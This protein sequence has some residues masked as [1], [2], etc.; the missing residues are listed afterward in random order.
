MASA[1]VKERVY[2]GSA[3]MFLSKRSRATVLSRH[4]SLIA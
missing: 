3:E 1:K 4:R 2:V